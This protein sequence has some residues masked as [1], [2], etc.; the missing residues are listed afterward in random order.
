MTE[1]FQAIWKGWRG[2]MDGLWLT[3]IELDG[4]GIHLGL[5]GLTGRPEYVPQLIQNLAQEPVFE[6]AQFDI[7]S[8]TKTSKLRQLWF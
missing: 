6:G 3:K 1:V 4:W 8:L 2:G 7:F 5:D